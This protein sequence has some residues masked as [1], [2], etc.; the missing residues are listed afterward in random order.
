MSQLAAGT[1]P[2]PPLWP[3]RRITGMSAVLL[4]FGPGRA[5]ESIRVRNVMWVTRSLT[6]RHV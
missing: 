1:R 3:G 2:L 5:V 4:P 6:A